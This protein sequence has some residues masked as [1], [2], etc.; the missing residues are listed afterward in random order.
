M[1]T[2]NPS[3]NP[4]PSKKCGRKTRAGHPCG[5]WAMHG[6]TVCKWHGGKA[7]QNLRKAKELMLDL[8]H[9]SIAGLER[10]IK[11]N[12]FRAMAYVLDWAGF[13]AV[14]RVQGEQQL[15]VRVVDEEQS[16]PLVVDVAYVLGTNGTHGQ[17][18]PPTS[19]P[20]PDPH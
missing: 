20:G 14:E 6:Q 5:H 3:H 1:A 15:I 16:P 8:V 11:A 7:P 18:G 12:E 4:A 19:G 9:P 17:A 2:R 10:L 13:K